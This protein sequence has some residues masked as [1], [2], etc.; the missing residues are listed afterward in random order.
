LARSAARAHEVSVRAVLG[1]S[2]TRLLR[3]FL[4]ES[5]TMAMLGGAVGLLLAYWGVRAM[6]RFGPPGTPRLE[7]LSLDWRVASVTLA[8]SLATGIPF[9]LAPALQASGQNSAESLKEGVRSGS[10]A[11]RQRMRG[12]LVISEFALSLMLL[13]GAGLMLRSF[14]ALQAIDPGFLPDHLLTMVLSVGGSQDAGPGEHSIPG[15]RRL[16]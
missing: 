9:G 10:G 4:A 2:R 1:A 7:T 16:S 6:V 3:Q 11:V 8:V 13:I 12:L 14:L 5:V 15:I